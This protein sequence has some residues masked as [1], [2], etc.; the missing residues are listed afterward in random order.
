M[1]DLK[2]LSLILICSVRSYDGIVLHS[3][4]VV[5]FYLGGGGGGGGGRG[6]R[7]ISMLNL[8]GK[9]SPKSLEK[10]QEHCTQVC[11]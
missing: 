4:S 5:K 11:A 7:L 9:V 3:G 10:K 2:C 8:G 6:G 1:S